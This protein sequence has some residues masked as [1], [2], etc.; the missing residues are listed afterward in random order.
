MTAKSKN[1]NALRAGVIRGAQALGRF[2]GTPLARKLVYGLFLVQALYLVFMIPI[3][4]PPDE[5]AHIRVAEQYVEQNEWSPVLKEQTLYSIGEITRNTDYFYH[6]VLSLFMRIIPLEGVP[7]YASLR[8]LSVITVLLTFFAGARLMRRLG[9][10]EAVT[11]VGLLIVSNI[12]QVLFM[13][14]AINQDQLTWLATTLGA[15]LLVRL[16]QKLTAV[17]VLALTSVILFGA[18]IKKTFLPIAVLFGLVMLALVI[19]R[20]KAFAPEVKKAF[21]HWRPAVIILSIVVLLGVGLNVERFGTNIIQY[22]QISVSCNKVHTHEQC[23]EHG[24][25]RRN[26]RLTNDKPLE[27]NPIPLTE[28]VPFW[29]YRNFLG[30]F[31]T[32]GWNGR[33]L[34]DTWAY[35]TFLSIT[36]V[37]LLVGLV[38]SVRR[39]RRPES[40]IYFASLGYIVVQLAVNYNMYLT[41]AAQGLALQGRYIF[42]IIVPL[43]LVLTMILHKALKRWSLVP[44]GSALLSIAVVSLLFWQSGLAVIVRSDLY[45][46]TPLQPVI[47]FDPDNAISP[48]EPGV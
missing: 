24:V 26:D 39:W 33:A 30:V 32:Q 16:W 35:Y 4:V 12:A 3:G 10:S 11:T 42:P 15:F 18:I 14:A 45:T 25:Y 40:L 47:L 31:G 41:Y 2:A 36:T 23:L 17:D 9:A 8:V 38:Y 46:T 27:F 48:Y 19:Y 44:V 21:T 43:V 1:T 6:Y 34:P 20:R 22:Q 7:L 5:L 13:S 28:F 29:Y 37:A